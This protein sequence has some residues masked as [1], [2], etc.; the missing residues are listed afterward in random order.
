[1]VCKVGSKSHLWPTFSRTGVLIW[2]L[3]EGLKCVVTKVQ[4]PRSRYSRL[5]CQVSKC[6][7]INRYVHELTKYPARGCRFAMNL[8]S[9]Q[10]LG[11][12][13]DP[14]RVNAGFSHA[15]T[16]FH[17]MF[18]LKKML[19]RRERSLNILVLNGMYRRS[20]SLWSFRRSWIKTE[21]PWAFLI[22][23]GML[24]LETENSCLHRLSRIRME[25]R[26][27]RQGQLSIERKDD[28]AHKTE[29]DI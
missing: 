20:A 6:W 27:H 12:R 22:L 8:A 1:M 25:W 9:E 17:S 10:F 29:T 18:G 3:L 26:V 2:S 24:W 5:A 13:L 16:R 21:I 15:L 19:N 4:M 11:E 7:L 23:P 28:D 14:R